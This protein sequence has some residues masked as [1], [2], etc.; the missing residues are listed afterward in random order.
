MQFKVNKNRI[1][2]LD[3]ELL[4]TENVNS[5]VCSFSFS[6]E[7]DDLDLFAVFY[8][9]D[10][11]NRFVQLV[12]G[13][14]VIPWEM[15]ETA[16]V[17]YIGAYGIKNTTDTV[18]KRI[19]SNAI[20]ARVLKSLDS[21]TSANAAPSPD[22]WEQYRAEV[23]GYRDA[24][25]LYTAQAETYATEAE[26][27][28]VTAVRSAS[29]ANASALLADESAVQAE[30]AA[31]SITVN[32]KEVASVAEN[33]KESADQALLY[34][35]QAEEIKNSVRIEYDVQPTKIGIKQGDETEFTYTDDLTGPRGEK[36]DK[37]D[38]SGVPMIT[39]SIVQT[40]S[41]WAFSITSDELK[42]EVGEL[43]IMISPS[44]PPTSSVIIN[45]KSFLCASSEWL[46][47]TAYL[48]LVENDWM[49]R[50]V[51]YRT[52]AS[53]TVDAALSETS[54]NPVQNKVITKA[55]YTAGEALE[56]LGQEVESLK[57]SGGSGEV[58]ADILPEQDITT[59]DMNGDGSMFGT[60]FSPPQFKLVEGETYYACW[61]GTVYSCVC[62]ALNEDGMNYRA[63]GNAS[64]A[65]T[66]EN[67]GEPFLLVYMTAEGFEA[68]VI[69]CT[70]TAPNTH[71]VRIYQKVTPPNLPI[72]TA[73]DNG[74]L[75]QVVDGVWSAVT[76]S[77]GNEVAY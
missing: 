65:T 77:N 35:N 4:T 9:D 56:T 38:S 68:N 3:N 27:N 11:L 32:A 46:T 62:V 30:Q 47:D 36:G 72:V 59:A 15:L 7:Y 20:S 16:G 57:E 14:C 64:L 69:A 44:S 45:G 54:E 70:D 67:T 26:G 19:T 51:G 17:L 39:P 28:A 63:I 12:N 34:R 73:D 31:A 61:D 6:E 76:I 43:F 25:K 37:G 1:I 18:E 49:I 10:D 29:Q 74:K 8:R 52:G 21:S 2:R 41:S 58:E 5:V 23:L 40:D 66:G 13:K 50:V 24:T 55:L 33:A 53:I 71:V 60:S 42:G 48:M 75:L 22:V